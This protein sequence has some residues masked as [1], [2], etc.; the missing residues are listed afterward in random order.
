MA[1]EALVKKSLVLTIEEGL[2]EQGESIFKRYTY[3]NID[4]AATPENLV[5]A[6]GAL[7]DLYDG[8]ASFNTVDTHELF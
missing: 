5:I 8:P 7:A 3:S 4:K 6:A 1:M 2:D